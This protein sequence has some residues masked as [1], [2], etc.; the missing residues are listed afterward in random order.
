MARLPTS[1][2]RR[3]AGIARGLVEEGRRLKARGAKRIYALVDRRS[4][5]AE[6]FW[7]AAG[8][9]PNE[10]IVQYSRNLPETA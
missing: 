8:F 1:P 6:P 9:V 5:P 4:E 10:N 3:R 2:Q 7:R